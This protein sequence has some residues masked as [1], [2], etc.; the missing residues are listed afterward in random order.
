MKK[1]GIAR[2]IRK[3]GS[4]NCQNEVSSGNVENQYDVPANTANENVT[5]QRSS[6]RWML[7]P[8]IGA[9][10]NARMPTGAVA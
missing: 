3:R 2:P 6:S 7:R 8:M 1:H 10:T 5:T 4:T 9:I